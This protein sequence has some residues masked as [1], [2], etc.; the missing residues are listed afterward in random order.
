[1]S[2]KLGFIGLLLAFTVCMANA[3]KLPSFY[4]LSTPAQN[5]DSIFTANFA[6]GSEPLLLAATTCFKS[7]EQVSGMN[8]ICFYNCMGSQAA[9]TI[10]AV[11]ICPLSIQN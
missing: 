9:I 10:G 7:G 11:E 4:T 5:N 8:K 3:A 1:M 6:Q 2:K